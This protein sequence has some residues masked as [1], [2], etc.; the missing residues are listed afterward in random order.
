M[1]LK[2]SEKG[3]GA[4]ISEAINVLLAK[5]QSRRACK[6]SFIDRL[7][8]PEEPLRLRTHSET[9]LVGLA[10]AMEAIKSTQASKSRSSEFVR[11]GAAGDSGASGAWR[12]LSR[13]RSNELGNLKQRNLM[14]TKSLLETANRQKLA[15]RSYSLPGESQVILKPLLPLN[16][17]YPSLGD[18]KVLKTIGNYCRVWLDRTESRPFCSC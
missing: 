10:D 15:F 16:Q 6:G 2:P 9:I 13:I 11:P 1:P 7:E 8:E 17:E 14:R 18:F 12:S 5:F 4:S 3:K